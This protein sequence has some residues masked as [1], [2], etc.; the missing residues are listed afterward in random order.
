[1]KSGR[2]FFW[3]RGCPKMDNGDGPEGGKVEK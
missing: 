2:G 1:M 3:P